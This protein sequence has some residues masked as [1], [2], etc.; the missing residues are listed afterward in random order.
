[1]GK[2]GNVFTTT[3][4]SSSNNLEPMTSTEKVHFSAQRLSTGTPCTG[5]CWGHGRGLC[6]AAASRVSMLRSHL[7]LLL[8]A[9]LSSPRATCSSA[10]WLQTQG[11]SHSC[12]VS[13][14]FS[15]QHSLFPRPG[16]GTVQLNNNKDLVSQL[17]RIHQLL[18]TPLC[19]S[20]CHI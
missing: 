12:S 19:T 20:K 13:V 9:P 7:Q 4:G 16:L 5:R 2:L 1:M 18:G 3:P 15:V 17:T 14:H 10:L 8:P 6:P 11:Q